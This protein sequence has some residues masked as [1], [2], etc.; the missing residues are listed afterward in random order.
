M[1]VVSFKLEDD[2]SFKLMGDVL[3]ELS[4]TKLLVCSSLYRNQFG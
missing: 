2:V 3:F 4:R 1:D